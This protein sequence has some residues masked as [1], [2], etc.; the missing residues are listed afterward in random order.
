M[1]YLYY[2]SKDATFLLW[3]IRTDPPSVTCITTEEA[4]KYKSLF[5]SKH[6]PTCKEE[7]IIDRSS[8]PDFNLNWSDEYPSISLLL[9][10][11]TLEDYFTWADQDHPELFV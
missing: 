9:T 5:W 6:L 7:L 3:E 8:Y 1:V 10:F 11:D 2:E 4:R